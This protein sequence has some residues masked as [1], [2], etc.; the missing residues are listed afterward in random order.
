M[1]LNNSRIGEDTETNDEA[2]LLARYGIIRIPIDYFHA[3]NYRYTSLAD[4]ITQ[5]KR[6]LAEA[7]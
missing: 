6:Q 3:G 1:T 2:A 5:A 4:A 7:P